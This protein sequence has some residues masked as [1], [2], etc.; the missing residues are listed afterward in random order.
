MSNTNIHDQ[1]INLFNRNGARFRVMDHV[2]EGRTDLASRIR[3]NTLAQAAKAM[4]LRVKRSKNDDRFFLAVVPGNCKVDM[5]AIKSLAGGDAMFAR[6]QIAEELTGCVLGSV[7]PVSF[8]P[9]L[10]VLFDERLLQEDELVFNSGRL[11]KS[12]FINREDFLISTS[13]E[14]A[15][16]SQLIE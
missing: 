3:G 1:L 4:V 15:K 6:P 16:I 5:K 13:P 8:H 11:D 9:E 10:T 14:L 12:I 2:A 7:P